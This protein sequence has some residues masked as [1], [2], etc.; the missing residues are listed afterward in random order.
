MLVSRDWSQLIATQCHAEDEKASNNISSPSLASTFQQKSPQ[1]ARRGSTWGP[2]PGSRAKGG[3]RSMV[4]DQ[5]DE[6]YE[7]ALRS[8]SPLR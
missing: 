6:N 4:R 7:S 5:I 3:K 8:L 1:K 2:D